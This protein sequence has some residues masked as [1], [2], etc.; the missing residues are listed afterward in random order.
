MFAPNNRSK[1]KLSSLGRK[2]ISIELSNQLHI[3]LS[4]RITKNLQPIVFQDNMG[5]MIV[6]SLAEADGALSPD[7]SFLE[8][9]VPSLLSSS[10]KSNRIERSRP[11]GPSPRKGNSLSLRCHLKFQHKNQQKSD[12]EASIST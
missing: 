5:R 12:T 7:V 6:A 10:Q 11:R 4:L 8:L 3:H 9:L 2:S 1:P